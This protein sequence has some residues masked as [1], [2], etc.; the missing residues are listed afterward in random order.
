MADRRTALLAALGT[1]KAAASAARPAPDPTTLL[2]GRIGF[3][4]REAEYTAAKSAGS[5][6]WLARQ[7]APESIDESAFDALITTALPGIAMSIGELAARLQQNNLFQQPVDELRGATILRQAWSQ[8]QL[9][10]TMV[11]F[12]HNHFNTDHLDG[13]MRLFKTVEDRDVRRHAMGKFGDL[14]LAVARS[15]AMLWYLDNA[16]SVVGAPNENYARELMELHTLGVNGGYVEADVKEVA[17]I[18]TGWTIVNY[19]AQGGNASFGFVGLRHD[20][21]A[22][23]V[24][25]RDFAAGRGEDE[26]VE[27]LDMLA[28]HPSTARFVSTK[29]VKRFV[30]DVPPASLVDK[31]AQTFLATGGDIRSVLKTILDSDE[32]RAS[33]DRKVKRPMEYVISAL[34]TVLPP[35]PPGSSVRSAAEEISALGQLHFMWPA[36]NGY[37][38]AAGYWV[39]TSAMLGR[40]TFAFA[41]A[42]D[43]LAG[44][45]LDLAELRGGARTP[46]ALVDRLAARL[47]HRALDKDDRQRLIDFAANGGP[48]TAVLAGADLA[49][50]TRELAGVLIASDYFQYR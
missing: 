3:G 36:P 31:A 29:L 4:A 30:D 49:Q 34:R 9:F 39:N 21:G 7:L 16:R 40:W 6:A 22:K 10:E 50:R 43:R 47:L 19:T 2:L 17:R 35:N 46:K 44:V 26:G 23:R 45:R 11:D 28:K 20:F 14:L 42:E 41:L 1:P 33:A 18:F 13:P 5:A 48:P 25:G 24:L 8:K 38:D 15:P 27:L 32:F 12:W 37:P